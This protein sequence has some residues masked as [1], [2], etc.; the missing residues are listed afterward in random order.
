MD[1]E[2]IE[3]LQLSSFV[4]WEWVQYEYDRLMQL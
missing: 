1:L 2:M 4:V 3:L